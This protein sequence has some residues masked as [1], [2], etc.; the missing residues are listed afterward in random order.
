MRLIH[1]AAV[2]AT[3]LLLIIAFTLVHVDCKT[4]E[5]RLRG[6]RGP[7]SRTTCSLEVF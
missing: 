7:A 5:P 2:F 4:Y 3:I 1:Y 6:L